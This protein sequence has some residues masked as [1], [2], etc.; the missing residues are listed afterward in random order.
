MSSGVFTGSAG[1]F[2]GLQLHISLWAPG[3]GYSS[4]ALIMCTQ[5][6]ERDRPCYVLDLSGPSSIWANAGGNEQGT[7]GAGKPKKRESVKHDRNIIYS[8]SVVTILTVLRW[9]QYR[10]LL[11]E[12]GR[13]LLYFIFYRL[14]DKWNNWKTLD[15][16]REHC[17][18]I[19][20]QF[21]IQL[22]RDWE[23]TD[24]TCQEKYFMNLQSKQLL[25]QSTKC[26]GVKSTTFPSEMYCRKSLQNGNTPYYY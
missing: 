9:F 18:I 26:R 6:R 12:I 23:Y 4:S 25:H 20:M 11:S 14:K 16:R 22:K 10:L 7:G 21:D 1:W 13:L 24:F 3:C 15:V 2:P 8:R 19:K 5:S 17:L